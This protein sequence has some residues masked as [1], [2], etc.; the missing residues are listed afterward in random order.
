MRGGQLFGALLIDQHGLVL[1]GSLAG[2]LSEFAETLGAIIGGAIEEAERTSNHL[3][4]GK[5]NGVLLEAESAVLHF[6]PVDEGLIVL[7]A[8]RRNAPAGW[9]LRAAQQAATIAARFLEA[10]A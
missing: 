7:L 9:V 2:G 10:Y 1:A 8:A 5:W 6:A 4:L 3:D